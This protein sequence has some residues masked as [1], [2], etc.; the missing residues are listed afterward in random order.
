MHPAGDQLARSDSNIC[1]DAALLQTASVLSPCGDHAHLEALLSSACLVVKIKLLTDFGAAPEWTPR[2]PPPRLRTSEARY[3][4]VESPFRLPPCACPA[5]SLAVQAHA[6][7]V[8]LVLVQRRLVPSSSLT[9]TASRLVFSFR[10]GMSIWPPYSRVL[11][12]VIPSSV[13]CVTSPRSCST[14]RLKRSARGDCD[15]R[16]CGIMSIHASHAACIP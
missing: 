6:R 5:T 4:V 8:S 14:W 16:S 10:H 9:G 3:T 12:Q 11:P 13:W 7:L 15:F 1:P 2:T